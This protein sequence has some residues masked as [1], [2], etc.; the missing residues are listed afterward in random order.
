M[1]GK[2]KGSGAGSEI[3]YG[4]PG[5]EVLEKNIPRLQQ[6]ASA[7]FIS[8]LLFSA[9]CTAPAVPPREFDC[10]AFRPT[11]PKKV[12]VKVSLNNQMLYVMEGNRPLMVTPTCVGKK[13]TPTPKGS[14]SIFLKQ[15][16]RRANTRG[17]WVHEARKEIRLGRNTGRPSGGG[18]RFLGYPMGHWC[19]FAPAYGIHAGWVHP[20]PSTRGCLR[21]HRNVA[22]KFFALV[23]VGT[24]VH[25][26]DSQVEDLTLGQGVLRP[27]DF[28]H[29][30][31]PPE[32][33]FTDKIFERATSSPLLEEASVEEK[34][35]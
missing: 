25:I 23:S 7:L 32:I 15:A 4:F 5:L 31:F 29:P 2:V 12:K 21:I 33:M 30:E 34:S 13:A 14:F 18:W 19:E 24:K 17:F 20:T 1:E 6:I 8:L 22:P 16:K 35:A 27:T 9:G 28:N 3:A 10:A 26:A 11:D